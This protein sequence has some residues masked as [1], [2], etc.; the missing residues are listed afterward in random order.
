MRLRIAAGIALASMAAPGAAEVVSASANGFHLRQTIRLSVSPGPAYAAFSEVGRW[1]N[2]SHSYSGKS[3]NLSLSLVAGSCF[4]ERLD[5]GGG[6]EH[7]RVAYADPGKRPVLT[8][9][10]GP[11]LYQGVAGAMDLE[12]KRSGSGTSLV[13]NYKVAGFA[14]GGADRLAPL[15]DKVLAEQFARYATFAGGSAKR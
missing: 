1:W 12:F 6:V 2:P 15:V 13:V 5:N 4:C 8:G 7:L 10:L 3:E 9:G 14:S 11:L